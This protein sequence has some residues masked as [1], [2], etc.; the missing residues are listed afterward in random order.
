MYESNR[1][2]LLGDGEA[3]QV[4]DMALYMR[5][6]LRGPRDRVTQIRPRTG[7]VDPE[8][9][10]PRTYG[11]E[12]G[13]MTPLGRPLAGQVTREADRHGGAGIRDDVLP[14][15]AESRSPRTVWRR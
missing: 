4:L 6:P 11:S 12:W 14:K 10:G 5:A 8:S 1:L 13:A 9:T 3:D 7:A 15:L 2:E